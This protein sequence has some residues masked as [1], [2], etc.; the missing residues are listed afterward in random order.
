[1]L[2]CRSLKI[3]NTLVNRKEA[4]HQVS[5]L[6]PGHG[7]EQLLHLVP[8][9]VHAQTGQEEQTEEYLVSHNFYDDLLDI[10][11]KSKISLK[12]FASENVHLFQQAHSEHGSSISE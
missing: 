9:P 10:L 1:M 12:I 4:L 5:D 8:G 6:Q 3:K 11:E 2:Y 7:A